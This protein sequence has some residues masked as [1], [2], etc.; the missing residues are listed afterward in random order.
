VPRAFAKLAIDFAASGALPDR[1]RL[2]VPGWNTTEN[3]NFLFDE[4]AAAAVM[5]A[6]RA[7]GV[8]LAID[9][10]HQMLE[11]GIAPDPTAKDARGWCQLELASDGSL[12]AINVRWTP[13]GAAR[14]TEKRQR[15]VSPAFEIDPESKRV[16]KIVNVAITAI[17]ATHQ[18][19]ALVAASL[20]R[21]SMDPKLVQ[22]ALDALIEGDADKCAELLKG[23]IAAAASS[24]A[25]AEAAPEAMAA[26]EEPAPAPA[27]EPK[28]EESAAAPAPSAE[29]PKGEEDEEEEKAAVVAASKLVR[30]SGKTSLVDAI[31][32]IEAWRKSHIELETERQKLATEKAALE[33]A[34]RRKLCVEL[35]TQGGL[36]PAAV[37][38]DEKCSAPKPYLAAMSI[39]DLR[40]FAKS[41][42][43]SKAAPKVAPPKVP[44]ADEKQ[45]TT[46]HGVVTLSASELKACEDTKADPQV[47]ANNKAFRDH[48]R[49]NAGR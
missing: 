20:K 6:Y 8:D 44:A 39:V 42:K 37:W 30:L 26:P 1:F 40:D 12:W 3:G 9:L 32:E 2:F 4:A 21:L 38:A 7:W 27:E 49:K 36:A 46:Q 22:Q 24:E 41:S 31:V 34:E 11:H 13:D 15:Y 25:P 43:A 23:A 45:F 10:E 29:A 35:V 48:A 28:P 18:T 33:S 14:L 47:Y 19:P 5:A 17:P 16:T